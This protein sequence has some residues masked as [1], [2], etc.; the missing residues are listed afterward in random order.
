MTDGTKG[1]TIAAD[2]R[3]SGFRHLAQQRTTAC[4]ILA[5]VQKYRFCGIMSALIAIRTVNK[6]HMT[7]QKKEIELLF[8]SLR[9]TS[10]SLADARARDSFMKPLGEAVDTLAADRK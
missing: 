6:T 2:W 8:A 5:F 9:D 3:T 7:F 10:P 4:A 1:G